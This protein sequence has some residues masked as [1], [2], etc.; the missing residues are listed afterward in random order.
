MNS[1]APRVATGLWQLAAENNENAAVVQPL[2]DAGIDA[3]SKNAKEISSP[4]DK[5]KLSLYQHQYLLSV[6]FITVSSKF[7]HAMILLTVL[8]RLRPAAVR[9]AT[10]PRHRSL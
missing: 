3:L 2:V 1:H 9:T 7:F 10:S 8:R 5:T 4:A 6:I